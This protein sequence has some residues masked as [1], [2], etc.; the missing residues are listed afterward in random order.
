[1]R[2]VHLIDT[3]RLHSL[4]TAHAVAISVPERTSYLSQLIALFRHVF[5]S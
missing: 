2:P 5:G 1:M 3:T 4:P